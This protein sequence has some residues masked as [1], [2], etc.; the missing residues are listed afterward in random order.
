M[1]TVEDRLDIADVLFKYAHALDHDPALWEEVFTPDAILDFAGRD[2]QRQVD[3]EQRLVKTAEEMG[4]DL[5]RPFH[6]QGT[7][8]Q[9]LVSNYLI[10]VTG[11]TATV[12]SEMRVWCCIPLESGNIEITDR[13]VV[14]DDE[15]VRR[16]EGWRISRRHLDV[17]YADTRVQMIYRGPGPSVGPAGS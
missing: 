3:N 13:I 17:R 2:S 7:V 10:D 12:K 4:A 14:C 8:G 1:T 15:L 16:P 9:H 11:D 5:A 6:D